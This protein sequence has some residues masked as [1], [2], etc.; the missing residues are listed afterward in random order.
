MD[1]GNLRFLLKER[2]LGIICKS[3]QDFSGALVKLLQSAEKRV[4][5]KKA[6]LIA[7]GKELFSVSLVFRRRDSLESFC[8][9]RS[10]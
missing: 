3:Q 10:R 7:L 9:S 5:L 1:K 8:L 2:T 4:E 6:A